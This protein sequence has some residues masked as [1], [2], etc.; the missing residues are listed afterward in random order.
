MTC[1]N[2]TYR[3]ISKIK[4]NLPSCTLIIILFLEQGLDIRTLHHVSASNCNLVFAGFSKIL[5]TRQLTYSSFGFRREV[6]SLFP[7]PVLEIELQSKWNLLNFFKFYLRNSLGKRD[8]TRWDF[9][10]DIKI[11]QGKNQALSTNISHPSSL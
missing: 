1:F 6:K 4:E 3:R 10:A 9:T 5:L 7:L 8:F 2:I 11:F